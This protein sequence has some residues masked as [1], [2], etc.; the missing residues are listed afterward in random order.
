[1]SYLKNAITSGFTELTTFESREIGLDIVRFMAI[2]YVVYEHGIILIPDEFKT[3]YSYLTIL[4]F[5]GVSVFFLLSGFLIG[6]ILNKKLQ[7]NSFSFNDLKK[8]WLRRFLRIVPNYLVIILILLLIGANSSAFN[9]SYLVFS[10]NLVSVHPAFFK[11][12]W[13]LS[14]EMWFYFLFPLILFLIIKLTKN[15]LKSMVISIGIFLMVPLLLRLLNF[16][17]V[18]LFDISSVRKVVVFR[19][20]SMMF[21]VLASTIYIHKPAFWKKHTNL[22]TVLGI[23]MIVV[24]MCIRTKSS[25]ISTNKSLNT[26][27]FSIVHFYEEVT[28]YYIE[29][30]PILFFFPLCSKIKSLKF[31]ILNKMIVFASK[32]SYSVYLTHASLILWFLIPNIDN[33][34]LFKKFGHESLLLYLTYMILTIVFSILLYIFIEAPFMKYREKITSKGVL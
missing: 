16:Y 19:L 24:I 12:A 18:D 25:E 9:F 26:D 22:S 13:S 30:L 4:P 23:L 5:D 8:F 21:G 28:I 20:D 7:R 17:Y 14:K 32:I 33:K 1:M 27:R 3:T 11:E 15:N 2:F 34:D 29:A 31:S 6:A 10:Q